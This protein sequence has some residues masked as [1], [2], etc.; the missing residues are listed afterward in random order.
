MRL[1]LVLLDILTVENVENAFDADQVHDLTLNVGKWIMLVLI[2]WGRL[3]IMQGYQV[4][5]LLMSYSFSSLLVRIL[6]QM[7]FFGP[8]IL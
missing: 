1:L 2:I 6:G 3:I 5:F 7:F 8:L 4:Q